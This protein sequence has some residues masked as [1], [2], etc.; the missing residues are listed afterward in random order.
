MNC[1]ACGHVNP[2]DSVFCDACG[3]PL[4]ARCPSCGTEN[5][6]GARF[7][8]GC[9]NR[10]SVTPS[11]EGA[12]SE[13]ATTNGQPA[14]SHS[15][16]RP[17][18]TH[19]MSILTDVNH[20]P[21]RD[22]STLE[23]GATQLETVTPEVAA[24]LRPVAP[25]AA[26]EAQT[27]TLPFVG[28]QR[29]LA[30]LT[31]ALVR[32]RSGQGQIVT[33]VGDA[34]TGKT[35]LVAELRRTVSQ[36]ELAWFEVYLTQ[37]SQQAGFHAFVSLLRE[38]VNLGPE[39]PSAVELAAGL[40]RILPVDDCPPLAAAL[41][42][43]LG[44]P[45]IGGSLEPE[46]RRRLLTRAFQLVIHTLASQQ[47]LVLYLDDVH[48]ADQ[49][50]LVFLQE[51]LPFLMQ[52]P[53]LLLTTC[54]PPYSPPWHDDA[55]SLEVTIQGLPPD[56]AKTLLNSLVGGPVDDQTSTFLVD[57]TGGNPLFLDAL[58]R[59]FTSE[60]YLERENG[61][62]HLPLRR[63]LLVPSSLD[64]LYRLQIERLGET[65]RLALGPTVVLGAVKTFTLRQ[66]SDL[67]R[68][69][70]TWSVPD[71]LLQENLDPLVQHGLVQ[72]IDSHNTLSFRHDV[73]RGA[74]AEFVPA[75]R[76]SRLHALWARQLEQDAVHQVDTS[77]G[78]IAFHY[79]LGDRA[80]AAVGM[81]ARAAEQAA[82]VDAF[83]EAF[84]HYHAAIE[85]LLELPAGTEKA[86]L[87][88]T[89]NS[90]LASTEM[91]N[92]DF[93]AAETDFRIALESTNDPLTKATVW[94]DLAS[95]LSQQWRHQDALAEIAEEETRIQNDNLASGDQAL[96]AQ[97]RLK[98]ERV[99]LL[100]S[101]RWT[102]DAAQI[103][104][105]ALAAL[106]ASDPDAD[107]KLSPLLQ[108]A[109][110]RL[111]AE[112]GEIELSQ[113]R[114]DRAEQEF[115][116][117]LAIDERLENQKQIGQDCNQLAHIAWLR[118]DLEAAADLYQRAR[119]VHVELGDLRASALSTHNLALVY[120]RQW[121]LDNAEAYLLE[122]LAGLELVGELRAMPT[123]LGNLERIYWYRGDF[124]RLAILHQK[125]LGLAAEAGWDL[126]LSSEVYEGRLALE[127]GDAEGAERHLRAA[128][129]STAGQQDENTLEASL[130]LGEA[131]LASGGLE[132]AETVL[133]A[134]LESAEERRQVGS[135]AL[136]RFALA[137]LEFRRRNFEA[138]ASE[139]SAVAAIADEPDQRPRL[140]TRHLLGRYQRLLGRLA[141]AAKKWDEA[142]AAFQES[143]SLLE[144]IEAYVESG[145]TRLAWAET[146]L[147]R[148]RTRD[149]ARLKT[150]DPDLDPDQVQD[151]DQ[152]QDQDE[153]KSSSE[154]IRALLGN[155]LEFF[156]ATGLVPEQQRAKA[157][158][159]RL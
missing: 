115:Q 97:S 63:Y 57:R 79:G 135:V 56:E 15:D 77:L 13:A 48:F 109:V 39:M 80:S 69:E 26:D 118:G 41:G 55:S 34:G 25:R 131:L 119:D 136:L 62:W 11:P 20:I 54:R 124:E 45:G 151:E 74:A 103:V 129:A 44:V 23:G 7:C 59:E 158:L 66:L 142:E 50:S 145:R 19:R 148:D 114:P 102:A 46:V 49:S 98:L 134:A 127:H 132:E 9:G 14:D 73:V 5:R 113:H 110:G 107:A 72:S 105:E 70:R 47:P 144:S 88:A 17:M 33:I 89:L 101:L 83:P 16:S 78:E 42:S 4:S 157:I 2:A 117:A 65:V 121:Q 75:L 126:T 93:E 52:L 146:L 24:A 6:N 37:R 128:L 29:E 40:A 10:L 111:S 64:E 68:A 159:D 3:A 120:W 112:L 61:V 99:G 51:M 130:L 100:R 58:V 137:E 90:G 71:S 123:A 35:R 150:I 153:D 108:D 76:A 133:R 84:A 81:H 95:L 31:T 94:H 53:V 21:D 141:A 139:A 38:M 22:Y 96:L 86:N 122:A 106:G 154:A 125:E 82:S 18:D 32:V 28:R 156:E 152:D 30:E 143:L 155:S 12:A 149:T 104:Q 36:A 140:G 147:G 92:G 87:G 67:L 60:H 1:P 116:R 27:S 85:R 91:R 138:A 8:R 43:F